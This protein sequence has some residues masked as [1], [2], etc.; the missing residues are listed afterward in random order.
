MYRD[1]E[2][3][4]ALLDR[5]TVELATR[6]P[7]D[8]AGRAQSAHSQASH[9]LI[10]W[11]LGEGLWGLDV[12][13]VAAV[14]P[15]TGC[16]PVPSRQSSCLGVIGR[17]GRFYSVIGL[18]RFLGTG[19]GAQSPD[20]VQP[21]HLL[22]LRGAAPYLALAVDRVLGRFDLTAAGPA[23]EL[24]GRLVAV[25]DLAALLARL[26]RPLRDGAP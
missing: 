21:G 24:D 9:P 2:R 12:A 19:S 6:A 4:A 13:A 18:R 8:A 23:L 7:R 14:I 11:S 1:H 5:R 25:F 15:F 20:E 17:S 16:A 22:L 26:G 3:A 10:I